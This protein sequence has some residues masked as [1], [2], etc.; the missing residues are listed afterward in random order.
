MWFAPSGTPQKKWS[1]KTVSLTELKTAEGLPQNSILYFSQLTDGRMLLGTGNGLAIYDG[2][3]TTIPNS[4]FNIGAIRGI[5][6]LDEFNYLI[7]Q[8]SSLL[9]FNSQTLEF[10]MRN[11]TFYGLYH[12]Q[13]DSLL[14]IYSGNGISI[15]PKNGKE[16]YFELFNNFSAS[17]ALETNSKAY[18][19]TNDF[20]LIRFK[21]NKVSFRQ[22]FNSFPILAFTVLMNDSAQ[23]AILT[24]D[25][26]LFFVDEKNNMISTS[27]L[28]NELLPNEMILDAIQVDDFRLLIHFEKA[29]FCLW[30]FKTGDLA[31]LTLLK[32]DNSNLES[33]FITRLFVDE[34]GII[35][36][37]TD[38][39][40]L[41]YFDPNTQVFSNS[42]IEYPSLHLKNPLFVSSFYDDTLSNSIWIG[43]YLRGLVQ[44]NSRSLKTI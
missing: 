27:N 4:P 12:E 10:S 6:K 3:S 25:A 19:Y 40:G 30:N 34:F 2:I 15:Y 9:N 37:G 42:R 26:K 18:F 38:G 11:N 29:G 7:Q 16:R 8:N 39:Y 33:V 32:Q 13:N 23:T 5:F 22:A 28:P 31:Q 20:H 24:E 35:W 44:L 36:L 41:Y 17:L 14:S 1:N 21:D 43:T